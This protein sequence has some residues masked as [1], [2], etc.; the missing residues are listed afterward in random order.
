V[1]AYPVALGDFAARQVAAVVGALAFAAAIR[2]IVRRWPFARPA[3]A[4]ATGALWAALTVLFE[5]ALVRGSGKPWSDV[6]EQYAIW[7]GSLWPLLVL[8]LLVAPAVLSPGSG[9]RRVA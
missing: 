5:V 6:G 4:W 1:V 8:W 3:H 7:K 9:P 2:L